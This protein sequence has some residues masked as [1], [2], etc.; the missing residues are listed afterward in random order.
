MKTAVSLIA[1]TLTVA[2]GSA[3]AIK[4]SLR[5]RPLNLARRR[6]KAA[7]GRAGKG[8][9]RTSAGLRSRFATH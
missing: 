9:G 5:T 4:R 7:L 8:L 2:M 1:V 3:W 6:A